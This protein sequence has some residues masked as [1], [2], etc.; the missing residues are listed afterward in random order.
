MSGGNPLGGTQGVSD[1][2]DAFQAAMDAESPSR[3]KQAREE[4]R[5]ET[6]PLE[7]IFPARRMDR[8]AGE[9]GAND[10]PEVVKR[11]RA[12]AK[13]NFGEVDETPREPI[14][15]ADEDDLEDE[16]EE[17]EVE[18]PE[19]EE[20]E[21]EEAAQGDL[22][23]NQVVEVNV[24][25]KPVQVS[26][27]EALRGYI[28]QET[29][30]QRMG[31]LANGVRQLEARRGEMSSY[32]QQ[33]VERAQMLEQ[34]VAT[35]MPKEPDWEAIYAADPGQGARLERQWRT[36][37][38]QVGDLVAK[39][40][41]T[42]RELQSSQ[43]QNIRSFAEANRAHL[44][45]AHPEWQTE[46]SWSRDQESMRRTARAVGYSD[47]EI[48]QL[49]DARGVEILL[50]AAKYDRLMATK[51]KP[52]RNGYGQPSRQNGATPAKG[53]NVSRSFERAEKRLS[54]TGSIKAAASVFEKILDTEG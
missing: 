16:Q 39:R 9:G 21:Q 23:L 33:F 54:R 46:K 2:T 22:D 3:S 48:D 47:Q 6:M 52:V 30:H 49:Y 35:F 53:G 51:P 20:E 45:K 34:Y 13:A 31:D 36:F 32:Q 24:D 29:F 18:E 10:I 11:R 1:A 17:P 43:S 27:D 4:K 37:M 40:E 41:Q 38:E 19:E 28:R 7:E 12:E 25:G 15:A 50:K 5:D 42:Q 44:A 8:S 14:E 26:L